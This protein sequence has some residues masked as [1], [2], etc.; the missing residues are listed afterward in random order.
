MSQR[1]GITKFMGNVLD[2]AKDLAD[3]VLDRARDLEHDLRNAVS[4]CVKPA[5]D[6]PRPAAPVSS[7]AHLHAHGDAGSA[8]HAAAGAA[9]PT[10]RTSA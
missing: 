6:A 3:D 1:T 2:G 9:A 5:D 8:G 7:D 10:E 4:R